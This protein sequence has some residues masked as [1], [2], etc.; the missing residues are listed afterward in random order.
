MKFLI[1]GL[2]LFFCYIGSLQAQYQNPQY[3]YQNDTRNVRQY[4]NSELL[5]SVSD[6]SS[7][8]VLLDRIRFTHANT[9]MRFNNIPP[10]KYRVKV[11][12][13]TPYGIA[14]KTLLYDNY[15]RVEPSVQYTMIIDRNTGS[16][17]IQTK[18]L[19]ENYAV[20]RTPNSTD[21]YNQYNN[22]QNE[23]EPPSD[24]YMDENATGNAQ[25][26]NEK[27]E[28]TEDAI[29][30]LKKDVNATANA[31]DKLNLMKSTLS[32]TDFTL[33]QMRT[34]LSWLGDDKNKLDF[35]K[36]GYENIRDTENYWRLGS[37][38]KTD[39]AKDEFNEFLDS[40]Q[41]QEQAQ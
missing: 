5:I 36:W 41:K 16:A 28:L 40:V 11:F 34:M 7:I 4:G 22:N 38:F 35:A 32:A 21:S 27:T 19:E 23:N 31:A 2:I 17:D 33:P 20:S 30:T 18:M 29:A 6:Q 3:D 12:L 15:L 14:R 26:Y 25:N 1:T 13:N 8:I 24:K 9:V 10:K 39:A 37:S